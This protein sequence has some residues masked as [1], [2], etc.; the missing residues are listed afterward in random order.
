MKR[1]TQLEVVPYSAPLRAHAPK[2][3]ASR[4]GIADPFGQRRV[5]V[6]RSRPARCST[7][8][9][10]PAA[11]PRSLRSQH[12]SALEATREAYAQHS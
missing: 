12:G 7:S 3:A 5:H 9:R 6:W 4:S 11:E 2:G 1:L 10:S 8:T